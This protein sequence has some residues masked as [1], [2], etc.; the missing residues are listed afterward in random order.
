MSVNA[1]L[2]TY[3]PDS[4]DETITSGHHMPVVKTISIASGLGVLLAGLI[5]ALDSE[6]KAVPYAAVFNQIGT[7]DGTAKEFS[8][9]LT[10]GEPLCPGSVTLTAGDQTLQDDGYGNLYGDGT[11]S[12]N[13]KTGAVSG[14]FD[15]APANGVAVNA[16]GARQPIGVLLERC[17]TEN[18][19]AAIVVVHGTV[20][21]DRVQVA[22]DETTPTEEDF[23]RL[24]AIGVYAMP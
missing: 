15:A 4:P 9:N 21:R 12:V 20:W 7:G 8:G 19:D 2:G 16:A 10:E 23:N 22:G 24:E 6:G 3:T 13:Y 14:T 5:L 18:E 11:G 17:D 1:V